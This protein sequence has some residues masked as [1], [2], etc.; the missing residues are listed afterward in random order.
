M[1]PPGPYPRNRPSPVDWLGPIPAHWQVRPLWSMFRRVK[2]IEHPEESM[3]SVFREYGVVPK[4][5]RPNLNVTAENRN[6]YQLVHP[7]WLVTNRMKAWQGSVGVSTLRGIVSGHYICFAPVH[8]EHPAYLNYLFRSVAYIDGYQLI[9][10]GVRIGQAEIDNDLYRVLPVLV[11]PVAEQRAIADYLDRETMQIDALIG[12]QEQLVETL[13]ERRGAVVGYAL[14]AHSAQQRLK[15]LG[16]VTLGKMLDAGKE[17][18]PGAEMTQYLRAANIKKSGTVDLSDLNHMPFTP[19]EAERLNLQA[20]DVLVVEGGAMGRPAYLDEDLPGTS[21]QKTVNR[22]RPGTGKAS[23]RFLY[24]ALLQLDQAGYHQAHIDTVS[25]PHLTAEKLAE[26][27]IP[28][29]PLDEQRRIA[30]HLDKR[31]AKIDTLIG[32]AERFIDLARERRSALI[33]AAVTGQI[34]VRTA[35]TTSVGEGV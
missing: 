28:R 19:A 4:A 10:R 11:P 17:P 7:G 35:N 13:A 34:D 30:A 21:F 31:T 20:D 8:Q 5:S 27:R 1:S 26:V 22:V 25:M 2:D 16:R 3:L 12:K 18:P 33:T 14:N 6:I 24:Y 32:K 29:V 15:Q 23:G 9:S